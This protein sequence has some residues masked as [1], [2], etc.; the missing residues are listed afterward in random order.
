MTKA[1]AQV[2]TAVHVVKVV[3][4]V[5]VVDVVDVVDVVRAAL[6]RLKRTMAMTLWS[7]CCHFAMSVTYVRFATPPVSPQARAC[8]GKRPTAF[9]A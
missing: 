9:W 3:G 6:R 4:I 2:V 1:I 8:T 7:W 5:Y